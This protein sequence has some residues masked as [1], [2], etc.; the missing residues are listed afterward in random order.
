MKIA[1]GTR[2]FKWNYFLYVAPS[3]ILIVFLVLNERRFL[4]SSAN[5]SFNETLLETLNAYLYALLNEKP[6]EED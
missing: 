5:V 4:F 6:H 3:N 2:K 1:R